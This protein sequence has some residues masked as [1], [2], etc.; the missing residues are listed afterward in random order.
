M[1][2]G[3][4]LE[5]LKVNAIVTATWKMHSASA[6]VHVLQTLMLM[7]FVTMSTIASEQLTIVAF[8]MEMVL[9]VQIALA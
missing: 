2:M 4:A 3:L 9:L 6:E 1:T 7:A 8:A 5:S